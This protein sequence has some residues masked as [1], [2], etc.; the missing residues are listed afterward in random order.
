M[1]KLPR[2]DTRKY[3]KKHQPLMCFKKLM[4]LQYWC[5]F[6]WCWWSKWC[7]VKLFSIN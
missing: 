7:S 2:E 5:N 6:W 3:V 1:M 4:K